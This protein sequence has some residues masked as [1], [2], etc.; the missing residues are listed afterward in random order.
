MVITATLYTSIDSTVSGS[1]VA[2]IADDVY[3]FTHTAL[4]IP[5]HA[6]LFG[7]FGGRGVAVAAGQ[8]R[9]PAS[10]DEI[11]LADRVVSLSDEPGIDRTGTTGLG[12]RV[13]TTRA[14]RSSVSQ[15]LPASG[16]SRA[17][18]RARTASSPVPGMSAARWSRQGHPCCRSRMRSSRRRMASKAS[19]SR[20][21]LRTTSAY[22]RG[23]RDRRR[24]CTR[25]PPHHVR[26]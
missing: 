18:I 12:A 14:R 1:I 11:Q 6:K 17:R 16:S 21:C 19:R 8:A 9:I 5:R 4:V 20:S 13:D 10:F 15:S 24:H 26:A 7:S 3:D 2:Y 25:D 23:R 22:K